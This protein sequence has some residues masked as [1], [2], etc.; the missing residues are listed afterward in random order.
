MNSEH[1]Q[2]LIGLISVPV[3]FA[4]IGYAIWR[5]NKRLRA[6]HVHCPTCGRCYEDRWDMD[7]HF[8]RVHLR[9]PRG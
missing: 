9:G 4:L 6:E 1:L 3:F 5:Y 2:F 8:R 7:E